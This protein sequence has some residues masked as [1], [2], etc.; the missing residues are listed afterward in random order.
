MPI[1]VISHME[2]LAVCDGRIHIVRNRSGALSPNVAR[3]SDRNV[4]YSGTA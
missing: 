2:N 4:S 3:L 1:A